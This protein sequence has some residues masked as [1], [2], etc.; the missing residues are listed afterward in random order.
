M[1]PLPADRIRARRRPGALVM[2]WAWRYFAAWLI[3]TPIV[4]AI[5]ATGIGR[6]PR[7]DA[8]LFEPGGL[9]LFEVARLLLGA[10]SAVAETTFALLMV[11]AFAGLIP[12]AALLVALSVDGR[13]RFSPWVSKALGHFPAFALLTGA[14]WLLQGAV[15][16]SAVLIFFGVRSALDQRAGERIADLGALA[17]GGAVLLFALLISVLHDLARAAVVKRELRAGA[18]VALGLRAA[19]ARPG[20]TALAWIGPAL[21][22]LLAVVLAALVVD[23][24]AVDR[25]GSGRATWAWI[26]HQL[27]A[28]A[29]VAL[30][31][32]WLAAALRLVDGQKPEG[33]SERGASLRPWTPAFAGRPADIGAPDDPSSGRAA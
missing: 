23:R 11:A 18:A 31:A 14:T 29:L 28:F 22:S 19:R 21:L 32:V 6:H 17:A 2:V 7:G 9:H 8:P 27:A 4:D 20:R 30:R 24:L 25:G 10:V 13:L 1:T 15:L 26:V 5:A 16:A 3:S 12:L 33:E